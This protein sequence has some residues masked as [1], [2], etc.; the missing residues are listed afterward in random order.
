M[1]LFFTQSL[2]LI[3]SPRT[4]PW[5]K[6]NS[7]PRGSSR[8]RGSVMGGVEELQD[9]ECWER[10][11][12]NAIPV[13]GSGPAAAAGTDSRE[14]G[15]W[16]TVCCCR[17]CS[18][19]PPSP[20]PLLL[21]RRSTSADRGFLSWPATRRPLRGEPADCECDSV[22][23]LFVAFPATAPGLDWGAHYTDHDWRPVWPPCW[24]LRGPSHFCSSTV[25]GFAP[26]SS[27]GGWRSLLSG[28]SEASEPA[29]WYLAR[30]ERNSYQQ[31]S[32]HAFS[33]LSVCVPKSCWDALQS[34]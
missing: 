22:L 8:P 15:E 21:A 14:V 31:V 13:C 12:L 34:W 2:L 19:S 24:S 29:H 33:D 26:R 5:W 27:P 7:W 1:V 16:S 23:G 4:L 18:P 9:S 20:T 17:R 28:S 10:R 3:L 11:C 25:Y 6:T 32:C 30:L